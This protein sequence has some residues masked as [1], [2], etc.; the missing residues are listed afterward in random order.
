MIVCDDFTRYTWV[1]CLK[2]KSDAAGKFEEFI[3]S[4]SDHGRGRFV[5]MRG[6]SSSVRHLKTSARAIRSNTS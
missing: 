2:H 6:A 4:V 1:L 5:L 3:S